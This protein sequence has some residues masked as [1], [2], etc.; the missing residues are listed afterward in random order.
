[1]NSKKRNIPFGYKYMNGIITLNNDE[2][3]I[4]IQIFT[5]YINGSSL[6]HISNLLIER[7]IE[8]QPKQIN[9]NKNKIKRIIEDK[10]YLGNDAYPQIITDEIYNQANSTKDCRNTTKNIDHSHDI[11][12]LNIPILCPKCNLRMSRIH[13]SQSKINEKWVC[14]ECGH[15]ISIFDIELNNRITNMLNYII[16]NTHLIIDNSEFEKSKETIKTE[17]EINRMLESTQIDKSA[18]QQ[19]IF[20]LAAFKYTDLSSN[21]YISKELKTVFENTSPLTA[22]STELLKRTTTAIRL[23]SDTDI[24]LILKNNQEIRRE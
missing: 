24:S 7:K 18:I 1:M 15:S 21:G 4:V 2:S 14:K 10:R 17:N 8:Y 9:W 6:L 20:E 13:Y 23:N 12:K 19:K 3:K 11:H 22:L 16:L 5:E